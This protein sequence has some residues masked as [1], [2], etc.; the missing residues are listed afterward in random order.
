MI[1][2]V[3]AFILLAVAALFTREF[4]GS[5]REEEKDFVLDKIKFGG[6]KPVCKVM[7]RESDIVMLVV[8]EGIFKVARIGNRLVYSFRRGKASGIKW[9]PRFERW[10]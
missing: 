10:G 8:P 6:K 7:L 1:Y 9:R 3:T 4:Y 5:V 2:L